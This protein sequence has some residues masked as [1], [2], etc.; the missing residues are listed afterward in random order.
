[1]TFL[2]VQLLENNSA[3]ELIRGK[4]HKKG[5]RVPFVHFQEGQDNYSKLS[6]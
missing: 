5:K 3:T 1:M 2:F 4:F 6:S